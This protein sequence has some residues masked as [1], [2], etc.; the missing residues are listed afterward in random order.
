MQTGIH[1][2]MHI[3]IHIDMHNPTYKCDMHTN[4]HKI[5]FDGL[6]AR[7]AARQY[8]IVKVLSAL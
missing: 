4:I 2:D 3:Y 5:E 1:P 7:Y 6:L 8:E